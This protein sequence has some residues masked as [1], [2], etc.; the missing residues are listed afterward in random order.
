MNELTQEKLKKFLHYDPDS[1]LFTWIKDKA[2]AKAGD[3][4]NSTNSRGYIQISIDGKRYQA[5]R[6][7][8]L[9]MLGRFPKQNVDHPNHIR[10]DNRWSNL[11]ETDHAGNNRNRAMDSRNTS[12]CVG[13]CWHKNWKLWH[14]Q[15][16][17]KGKQIHLG[18]FKKIA[19]AIAAR[20][21]AEKKYGFHPN[22]GCRTG[23]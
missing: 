14:A 17:V 15:I 3:K 19:D 18:T 7:A 6:L 4:A 2:R 5:H 8:F 10:S 9:Y 11:R 1:G 23:G 12:G 16:K 20:K 13:V 22:H 21:V